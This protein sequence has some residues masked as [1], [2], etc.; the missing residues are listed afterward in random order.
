M[1][2]TFQ[3]TQ[4]ADIFTGL[5]KRPD[6]TPFHQLDLQTGITAKTWFKRTK[7]VSGNESCIYK[8]LKKLNQNKSPNALP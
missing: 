1:S 6:F 7:P 4:R 3:A 5:G 2:S 8:P